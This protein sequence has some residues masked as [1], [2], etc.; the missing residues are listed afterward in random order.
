MRNY[1]VG[2]PSNLFF[3]VNL[4]WLKFCVFEYCRSSLILI[5]IIFHLLNYNFLDARMNKLQGYMKI[6]FKASPTIL[7]FAEI[8]TKGSLILTLFL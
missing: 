7:N 6:N 5:E 2:N 1:L 8:T 4:I 3:L